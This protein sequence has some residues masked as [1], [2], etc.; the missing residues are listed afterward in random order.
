MR[1]SPESSVRPRLVVLFGVMV[2]VVVLSGIGYAMLLNTVRGIDYRLARFEAIGSSSTTT[3]ITP[4]ITPPV[5]PAN[6]QRLPAVLR[7]GRVSPSLPLFFKQKAGEASRRTAHEAQGSAIALTSDGW[8]V[9]SA[10]AITGKKATDVLI[11]W[12]GRTLP[13]TRTLLDTSTG[14]VFARIDAQ[15][16]PAVALLGKTDVT[17]GQGVWIEDASGGYTASMLVGFTTM[18]DVA[19]FTS[20]VWNTRMRLDRQDVDGSA[21]WSE[22][23]RL[24]GVRGTDALV[25]PSEAIRSA[26]ASIL[27]R[28]DVRRPFLGV[29]YIDLAD[30]YANELSLIPRGARVQGDKRTPAVNAT[31]PA[32]AVLREGDVIERVERDVLDTHWS[33]A[34]RLFEYQPGT[35]LVMGI[36]RDGSPLEVRVRIGERVTSEVL[37]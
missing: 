33:L 19:L 28:G 18:P 12:H 16:L 5:S 37:P 22:D 2:G 20:D 35:T 7:Q 32:K 17:V 4:E 9:L 29:Q 3:I 13:L 8:L 21:V 11:G 36:Q 14:L 10:S 15:D 6:G 27:S 26:L 34:E 30:T 25:L 23:G 24:V 1:M 31:S